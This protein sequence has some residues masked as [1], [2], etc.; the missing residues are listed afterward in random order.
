[1]ADDDSKVWVKIG[2]LIL[3]SVPSIAIEIGLSEQERL[4][5]EEQRLRKGGITHE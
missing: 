5:S 3:K 2:L 1:M 4:A